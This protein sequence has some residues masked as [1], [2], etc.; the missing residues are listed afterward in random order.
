MNFDTLIDI[1]REAERRGWATRWTSVDALR[2]QVKEGI[3]ILQS[4]MREE[5]DDAI[6]AFRCLILFAHA[7]ESGAGGIATVDISPER[8]RSLERID[9]DPDTREAFARIF[10]LASGGIVMVSK[11]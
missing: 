3:I 2:G 8:F 5:R 6:K 11:K 10:S 7:D 1:Q 4:L 9:C